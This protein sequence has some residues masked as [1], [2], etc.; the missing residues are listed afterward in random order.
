MVILLSM[1]I[2][3]MISMFVIVYV[4]IDVGLVF[5]IV[6]LEL[7]NKFVLMMLVIDIIVM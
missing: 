6:W 1:C 2:I 3:S 5:V 4:S 7:M